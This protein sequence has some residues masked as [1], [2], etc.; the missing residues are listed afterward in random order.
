MGWTYWNPVRIAFGAGQ[1]DQTGAQIAGRPYALVTYGIDH[2]R[3]LAAKLAAAAGAP[4][5]TI[6]NIDTNPDFVDLVESCRRFGAAATAPDVI[7]ALGGGSMID[8]AK[9]LAAS[10]GDFARVKRHLM[11]KAP[12]DSSTFLPIIAVPTTSGTGS[13]V[14]SWATVWDAAG[15][16][17]YSLANPRLYPE[18][19]FVDPALTLA[20]PRGLTMTTGLDALSHSLESLWNVNANPVSA[21]YAVEAAR[22]IIDALPRLLDRLNDLDLRSRLARASLFAGLA[23]SN[24]KTALAHNISYGITLRHG[25]PHGI[26]CSFCL[27]QVMEWAIGA[28]PA[29]DDA[30]RRIFGPDLERGVQRLTRLLLDVGV[31]TKPSDH[32]VGRAEWDDLVER[33]SEGERGRNFIG[34]VPVMSA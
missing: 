16:A 11:E 19:A 10:G 7:V 2:F 28:D 13:E 1:F 17:K 29:C 31:S 26:A 14:T 15:N 30:L 8:A 27:P 23:F 12:L 4:V 33:A 5:V 22:E 20:A 32:G 3:G 6:D 34:H 25:T 24:T 21:N 18:A 9:V